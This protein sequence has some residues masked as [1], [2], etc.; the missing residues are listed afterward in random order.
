MFLEHRMR[1]FQGAF[2][3]NPDYVTWYGLAE[4]NKDLVDIRNEAENMIAEGERK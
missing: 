1:A 2:H 4:L 3:M